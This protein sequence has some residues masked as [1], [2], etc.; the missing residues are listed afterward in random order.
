MDLTPE[1]IAALGT[2]S[3]A[4][5]PEPTPEA[6]PEPAKEPEKQP[7]PEPTPEPEAAEEEADFTM[8]DIEAAAA[9][10]IEAVLAREKAAAA[11][12]DPDAPEPTEAEKRAA[13]LEAE[14]AALKA[15]A[16]AREEA[17][18]AA[19]EA[20]DRKALEHSV[21]SA[22]G[23]Y[24]MTDAEILAVGNYYDN[25]P[26]LIG[27]VGFEAAAL[28]VHP[29]L[30]DRLKAP[31]PTANGAGGEGEAANG[32]IATGANG[33]G[34]PRPF[35]HDNSRRGYDD[36]TKHELATGGASLLGSYR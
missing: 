34:A 30:K 29:H 23:K 6:T 2:Q 9:K 27:T 33:A 32:F 7:D 12:K 3:D 1:E 28:R 24:K 16:K 11:E 10:A 19:K 31:P 5:A 13:A 14:V 25:N 15:Q 18:A 26:D 20:A 17:D 21:A 8:E 35:K 36:I 4:P 22:A